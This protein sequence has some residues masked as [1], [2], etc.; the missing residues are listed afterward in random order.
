[1]RRFVLSGPWRESH[2]ER[3]LGIN[4]AG[5]RAYY[6]GQVDIS[7]LKEV[8][9]IRS[10]YQKLGAAQSL[11]CPIVFDR[12]LEFLERH[13]D[14]GQVRRMSTESAALAAPILEY[15]PSHDPEYY[16]FRDLV[17]DPGMMTLEV[18]E[19]ATSPSGPLARSL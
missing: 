7:G 3:R 4:S 18:I 8:P 11:D 10:A 16:Q 1:M 15:S 19:E 2:N 14:P 13:S 12:A 17:S 5:L 6:D 9:A